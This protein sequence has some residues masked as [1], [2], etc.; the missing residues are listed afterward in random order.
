VYLQYAADL[1]LVGLFLL[2]FLLRN[3]ISAAREVW[4][5]REGRGQRRELYYMARALE[6]SV[7]AFAFGAL[8]TPSGYHF[9][10][11]YVGGMALAVRLIHE[12]E[13]AS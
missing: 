3:C 8:F 1:G 12:R 13:T 2:L 6:L 10:L 9:Y 11:F 5:E 4:K 7:W